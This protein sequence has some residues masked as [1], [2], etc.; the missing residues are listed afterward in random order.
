MFYYQTSILL[1]NCFL[2]PHIFL[3]QRK[4]IIIFSLPLRTGQAYL[5]WRYLAWLYP[6]FRQAASW[7]SGFALRSIM[8]LIPVFSFTT[9]RASIPPSAASLLD[10]L[11]SFSTQSLTEC[12]PFLRT[13]RI[14]PLRSGSALTQALL[15]NPCPSASTFPFSSHLLFLKIFFSMR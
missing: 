11:H 3:H 1:F 14:P 8:H 12:A 4:Y 10:S 6:L 2:F 13:Y 15:C 9:H 5:L 7:S